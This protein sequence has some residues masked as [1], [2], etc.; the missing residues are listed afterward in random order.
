M[1][2]EALDDEQHVHPAGGSAMG[3]GV[4]QAAMQ[5]CWVKTGAVRGRFQCFSILA[6]A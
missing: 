4:C 5:R 2:V 1:K 6:F 3:C